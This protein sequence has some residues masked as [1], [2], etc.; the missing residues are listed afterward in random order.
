MRLIL[1]A[2]VMGGSLAAPALAAPPKTAPVKIIDYGD[3]RCAFAVRRHEMMDGQIVVWAN[4]FMQG[5]VRSGHQGEA[6]EHVVG[7]RGPEDLND[8]S[9]LREHIRGY[10]I[11]HRDRSVLSAVLAILHRPHAVTSTTPP[12]H[13]PASLS[14]PPVPQQPKAPLQPRLPPQPK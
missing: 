14:K 7:L 1:A 12:P 5:Y 13:R 2:L 6:A 3:M 9:E 8:A 4:G 10:C 11:K